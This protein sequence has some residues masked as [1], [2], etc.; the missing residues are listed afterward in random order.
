[1]LSLVTVS[2][3]ITALHSCCLSHHGFDQVNLWPVWVGIETAIF[4]QCSPATERLNASIRC[5]SIHEPR[6]AIK[7]RFFGLTNPI[8]CSPYLF[9]QSKVHTEFVKFGNPFEMRLLNLRI[10]LK[11]LFLL[12]ILFILFFLRLDTCYLFKGCFQQSLVQQLN[13]IPNRKY[14]L[15]IYILYI[16]NRK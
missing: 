6:R 8:I 13:H 10:N 1:M 5:A 9:F 15:F 3:V 7:L 4:W 2:P 16:Y 11:F 14:I 12:F